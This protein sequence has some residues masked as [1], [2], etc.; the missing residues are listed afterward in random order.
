M[1]VIVNDITELFDKPTVV[2]DETGSLESVA[3]LF[4]CCGPVV[5]FLADKTG[6]P[7]AFGGKETED[8]SIVFSDLAGKLQGELSDTG[9]CLLE[10]FFGEK[11]HW[12]FAV[13]LPASAENG[14][15]GIVLPGTE[16]AEARLRA[17][18][19]MLLTCGVLAWKM[20]REKSH[21]NL[22][23]AQLQ[24]L[25]NEQYTLKNSHARAVSKALEEHERRLNEQQESMSRL[26]R[27]HL[28]NKMILTSAGEG[29]FGL[30][31][32]GTI[33]FVNPAGAKM[34]GWE[35]EELVG[36]Q[37]HPLLH[38]TKQNGR[39]RGIDECS[40]H[41]TLR[42]GTVCYGDSEVF[43]KKDGTSF[44][45]EYTS[46][47]IMEE[48]EIIGAVLTFR[49][50]TERNILEQQLAQ[51]QK[52]ESIGNL[53]AGIAHEINTPTQ[54]ISDNTRFFQDALKDLLAVLDSFDRLLKATKSQTVTEELVTEVQAAVE[55]ADMDYLVE[56]MSSAIEQSLEGV[57]R[58]ATIVRSMK[59][60]SHPGTDEKQAVDINRALENTLTV[61]RNEW[62]YVAEAVTQFDPDL[63][64][65]SCLPGECNQVFL[66]LIINAAHAITDKLGR[67]STKKGTITLTT[68]HDGNWVEI[69]FQDNGI[70]I[71]ESARNK[72]MDPFYTTKEVGRGTGQGLAIAHAVIVEKHGGML[73]FETEYGKG[74]TF[75]VR[76]PIEQDS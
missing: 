37:S 21:G 46:T 33:S 44:P 50:T 51:A 31:R 35:P 12:V 54:Y 29:I 68:C 59:E 19:E 43:W 63:P 26:E 23:Q 27:L 47:P 36:R 57:E 1:G 17:S 48:D 24:Q 72:I 5:V 58:V 74:T 14:I 7:I 61:T 53:A 49:D 38:H 18:E 70:G 42:E 32:D 3:A 64:Q 67:K 11:A 62:K 66:N 45:V 41:A 56:E 60:F 73:D 15:L 8:E 40:I 75:I 55:A 34:V 39:P 9:N 10:D 71:P 22:I 76:L 4:A 52:L 65:V 30:E 6:H 13:R 2:R 28:Q 16:K 69:R 20:F 25:L